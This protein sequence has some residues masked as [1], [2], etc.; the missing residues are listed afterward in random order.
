MDDREEVSAAS[1]SDVQGKL[2][3]VISSDCIVSQHTLTHTHRLNGGQPDGEASG[4]PKVASTFCRTFSCTLL[5]FLHCIA[6]VACE[7]LARYQ[8]KVSEFFVCVF[9]CVRAHQQ[10][11][12]NHLIKLTAPGKSVS[13]TVRQSV[14]R[15]VSQSASQQV[16]QSV[17][18]PASQ[19][20]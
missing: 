16:S 13:Q 5:I 3:M 10:G 17:C 12:R 2:L 18:R 11:A 9:L 4:R 6:V 1:S 14:S 8:E 7:V 19:L 15:P 20:A